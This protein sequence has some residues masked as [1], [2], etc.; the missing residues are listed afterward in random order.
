MAA[1]RQGQAAQLEAVKHAK[2]A[3]LAALKEAQAA[4]VATIK[5]GQTAATAALK[6]GQTTRLAALKEAQA[7][8]TAAARAHYQT[9]LEALR[10]HGRQQ[11]QEARDAARAA[12]QGISSVLSV[13]GSLGI[14][15]SIAAVA[16]ALKNIAVE[17]VATA[18]RMQSLTAAFTLISG[19]AGK[20]QNTL[21]FLRD[22]STRLGIDFVT[23]AESFKRFDAA[24]RGTALEGE[25]ARA[26]FTAV[27]QAM[28]VV[29]GTADQ[30]KGALIALE[31][32][33]SK[34]KVSSEEL[35]GQ[36]R[37]HLPGAFQISA[38]AMGVTTAQ[39][40][41][42]LETTD[43]LA[44]D[45]L[46]RLGAQLQKEFGPGLEAA[47]QTAAATFAKL[48]NEIQYLGDQFGQGL[49]KLIKPSVAAIEQFLRQTREA[50]A[51]QEALAARTLETARAGKPVIGGAQTIAGAA[52]EGATEAEAR[53]APGGDRALA[54]AEKRCLMPGRCRELWRGGCADH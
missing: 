7:A 23:S 27:S 3:E 30:T 4:E 45:F 54:A 46:P 51:A 47:A 37:E 21:A 36:L 13:A 34:G 1:V 29:G 6:E 31:Q 15:T 43:L 41:K 18:T 17:S 24:A 50:T 44:T 48:G 16:T 19:G 39:L 2:P 33:I 8:E 9:A 49:L 12:Q 52:P 25:K 26:I 40:G 53:P 22:E 35:R 28:R 5:Q 10:Q 14:A 42:M 11:V 32:I 38:R 20:A